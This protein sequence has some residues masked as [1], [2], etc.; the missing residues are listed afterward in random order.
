MILTVQHRFYAHDGSFIDV[1]TIGEAMDSG[2]KAS[3]K[4]M[5]AAMK[6]A[7][8]ELLA[9]PTEGDNDTENQTHEVQSKAQQEA[10][11]LWRAMEVAHDQAALDGLAAKVKLLPEDMRAEL[12]S[13]YA[14]RK[15][16]LAE[17][18]VGSKPDPFA[19]IDAAPPPPPPDEDKINA[20]VTTLIK[21]LATVKTKAAM[22]KLVKR[23]SALPLTDQRAMLE[24]VQQAAVRLDY[25]GLKPAANDGD[26]LPPGC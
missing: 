9:I 23:W 6:Y 1:V 18:T 26:D 17:M 16:A 10:A 5:S 24:H 12:R 11:M 22:A 14:A 3:N 21:E 25:E 15:K 8:I 20:E 19:A 2:D 4:A 13:V 7:L